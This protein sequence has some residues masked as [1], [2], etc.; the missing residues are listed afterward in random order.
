MK[1]KY[2]LRKTNKTLLRVSEV[3]MYFNVTERT[4]YLWIENGHLETEM[5]P[6]GQL[7]ITKDS[8]DNCRFANRNNQ[9]II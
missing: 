8:V 5:T 2:K 1:K 3:A 7:R 4:V 6:G 9:I